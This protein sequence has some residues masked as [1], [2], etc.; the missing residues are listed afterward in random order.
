MD[1]GADSSTYMRMMS[2]SHASSSSPLVY[3]CPT[4]SSTFHCMKGYRQ[5]AA[6]YDTTPFESTPSTNYA[7]I[8]QEPIDYTTC[9]NPYEQGKLSK[10]LQE[11]STQTSSFSLRLDFAFSIADGNFFILSFQE[12]P[13]SICSNE[14]FVFFDD[15]FPGG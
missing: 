3:T 13:D 1:K 5:I 8:K 11:K 7:S 2:E 14:F 9:E 4:Q 12:L 6:A 10:A 15:F